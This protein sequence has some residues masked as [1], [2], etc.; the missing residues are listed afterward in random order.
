MD[1]GPYVSLNCTRATDFSVKNLQNLNYKSHRLAIRIAEIANI[2]EKA[3][4]RTIQNR[5]TFQRTEIK[6]KMSV[7]V[8]Y[9]I[10]YA[11]NTN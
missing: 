10:F 9:R 7:F 1:K 11:V 3:E 6:V 5:G 4:V 8:C 2:T